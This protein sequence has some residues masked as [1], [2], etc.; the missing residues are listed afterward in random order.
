LP[1][2]LGHLALQVDRWPRLSEHRNGSDKRSPAGLTSV[3]SCPR[4]WDD[5]SRTPPIH[6][7]SA[8]ISVAAKSASVS[9]QQSTSC[10]GQAP[11]RKPGSWRSSVP[12]QAISQRSRTAALWLAGAQAGQL[13]SISHQSRRRTGAGRRRRVPADAV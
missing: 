9:N 13:R 12:E 4:P 10:S 1:R 3:Q 7:T 5:G 11:L 2:A 6:T 8:G